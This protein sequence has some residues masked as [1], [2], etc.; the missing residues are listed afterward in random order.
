MA[1]TGDIPIINT[2]DTIRAFCR[3]RTPL[4]LY[5]HED[6]LHFDLHEVRCLLDDEKHY[7]TVIETYS[8]VQLV[9]KRYLSPKGLQDYLTLVGTFDAGKLLGL[10]TAALDTLIAKGLVSSDTGA[11]K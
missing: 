3:A 9:E 6:C 4:S 10:V 11:P 1:S 7:L 8:K 2:E 5:A